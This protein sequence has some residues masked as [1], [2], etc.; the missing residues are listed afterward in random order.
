MSITNASLSHVN[1]TYIWEGMHNDAPLYVCAGG[2]RKFMG[3]DCAVVLR[4]ERMDDANANVNE[5]ANANANANA[6]ANANTTLDG[7][8]EEGLPRCLR[9]PVVGAVMGWE[10]SGGGDDDDDT[11]IA[12]LEGVG[13]GGGRR[14]VGGVVGDG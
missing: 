6:D 1:G 3:R 9:R 13:G 4:R 2:P 12:L 14:Q 8:E 10:G 11:N 7:W 5:N